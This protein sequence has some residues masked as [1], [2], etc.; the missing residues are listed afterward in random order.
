MVITL[1]FY[2]FGKSELPPYPLYLEDYVVALRELIDKLGF[3]DV[4]LVGHSF[5]GRVALKT[6]IVDDRVSGIVLVDSAGL[7]PRRNLKYYAK[8]LLY[9]LKKK[10]KLNI[11]NCGSE[12]YKKL[13]SVEK[14]TFINVV[15]EDLAPQLTKIRIPT[16]IIW[17]TKDKETPLYMA[18]KLEK[19]IE[20]SKSIFYEDCGHFPFL[21]KPNRFIE[22][23]IIFCS[24]IFV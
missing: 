23:L 4:I 14:K 17:G 2:G 16:L 9:K 3:Q 12:D 5:G 7:R 1:D 8:I 21:E 13:S 10:L 15:N 19:G 24:E 22:D 6:S 20:N 18:R 11:Q